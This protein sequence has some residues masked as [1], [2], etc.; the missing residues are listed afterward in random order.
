VSGDGVEGDWQTDRRYHGGLDRAVCIFSEEFYA[1]LREE[2]EIDLK[3]GSVGE[4][5]TTRGIDLAALEKGDRLRVGEC[6]IELTGLRAPCGKLK[7]WHP[8]LKR[9][10]EGHNGWLARVIEGDEVRAGDE[11]EVIR[12]AGK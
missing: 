2:Y 6:L 11:I 10:I 7:R 3:P 4:N 8:D 12:A 9:I 1:W 5:F